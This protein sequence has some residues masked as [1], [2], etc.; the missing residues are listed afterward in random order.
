MIPGF[1]SNRPLEAREENF[2]AGL[3]I[4]SCNFRAMVKTLLQ[5]PV[6]DALATPE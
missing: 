2:E 1:R 5:F 3:A 6:G 4:P